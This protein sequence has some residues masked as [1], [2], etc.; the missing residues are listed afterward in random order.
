M[1]IYGQE[2][3]SSYPDLDTERTS[4]FVSACFVYLTFFTCCD[5]GVNM[6]IYGQELAR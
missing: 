4:S 3:A 5:I 6:S 1:S 2:L